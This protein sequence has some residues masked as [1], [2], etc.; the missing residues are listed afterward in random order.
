LAKWNFCERDSGVI[1][2]SDTRTESRFFDASIANYRKFPRYNGRK[3]T[4]IEEN[5]KSQPLPAGSPLAGHWIQ[6]FCHSSGSDQIALLLTI[7]D[8]ICPTI[9]HSVGWFTQRPSGYSDAIAT[10]EFE[11]NDRKLQNMLV[12]WSW[13]DLRI[14]R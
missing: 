10:I 1:D 9:F 8:Y 6:S 4:C 13:L 3:I 2:W 7:L 14:S 11:S 12:G 5:Q